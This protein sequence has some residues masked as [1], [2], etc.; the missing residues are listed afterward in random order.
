MAVRVYVVT[1]TV[2]ATD[3]ADLPDAQGFVD[4]VR[5]GLPDAWFD[6]DEGDSSFVTLM[7]CTTKGS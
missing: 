6:P 5:D 7:T 2:E 4:G 1:F 3:P